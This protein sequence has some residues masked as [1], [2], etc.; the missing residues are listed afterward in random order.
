MEEDRYYEA[1]EDRFPPAAG[2]WPASRMFVWQVLAAMAIALG[3]WYIHWRWTSSIN[4]HVAWF[5]LPLVIA[6]T[7]AFVGA[8]LSTYN[9][10]AVGDTKPQ[11]A[12]HRLSEIAADIDPADDRP[13]SV[14]VFFPTYSEDPELVRLSLRD[15]KRITYPHA[16][17]TH[18]WVLDDGRRPAMQAVA[19]QEGVGYI[20]RT[21]NVGF[22]AGNLHNAVEK[23]SA[24]LIVICDADTRPL[25]E[26][27][28]ETLGYFRDPK[29]A[30]VQT[31][32]WFYDIPDG[33]AL[34]DWLGKLVGGAGRAIGRGVEAV[35]GPVR[36]GADP[37]GNEATMF[38]DVIQ[39]R[40]NRVN[41]AFCCGATS[42]HRRET[43]MAAALKEFASEVE[44]F[45]SL[46]TRGVDAPELADP[47][48]SVMI[49]E[50]ARELP[51]MPYKY[52]VSEDIFTSLVL[53]ADREQGWRSVYHPRPLSRML[54]P[55]DLLA[56]TLQR[57]K[58]AGGTLD[59]ARTHNPLTLPG[60]TLAQRLMYFST[61]YSYFAWLWVIV[62]LAAP[63][64]YLFTGL[65]PLQSY[66][67][68]FF[69]HA[70]PFLFINRLAYMVGTWGVDS[71]R[72][73]EYYIAS[74][75]LQARAFWTVLKGETIKF[76]VTPKVRQAGSYGALVRPH[77]AF[78]A[79][80]LGGIVFHGVGLAA[81]LFHDMDAYVLNLFWGAYN[82]ATLGV[83]VRAAFW[84]PPAAVEAPPLVSAAGRT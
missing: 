35:I 1:F 51:V 6:E 75:H 15:A 42:I 36:I 8:V 38:F 17:E 2:R 69:V 27:L 62:F 70:L 13:I 56:W 32:Q 57:F 63:I 81:G 12:P 7:L 72:G 58:Y 44:N 43:V 22:K 78:I 76:P 48:R 47:L 28:S 67:A 4:W 83:I 16:I 82:V 60:L 34:P 26:L 29:V 25:P 61:V 20:T 10:W 18:I 14:D 39:R 49:E 3:A 68:S 65:I 46:Q 21:N 30:W 19:E 5:S 64:V 23:T 9:L 31:P 37:F 59:I 66:G 45:V 84:Q 77:L 53:H 41:A 54:S 52:H 33:M 11:P 80:T 55:Q 74:F 73:E 71:A 50:A 40:R 24:D 79:L